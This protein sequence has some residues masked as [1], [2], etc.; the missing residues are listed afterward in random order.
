M[1]TTGASGYGA[2]G[3][4]GAAGRGI[5]VGPDVDGRQAGEVMNIAELG[6]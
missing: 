3:V 5:G 6:S 4:D 2:D 1:G